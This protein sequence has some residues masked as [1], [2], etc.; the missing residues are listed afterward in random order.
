MKTIGEKLRDLRNAYGL[1][2]REFGEKVGITKGSIN[3]YENNVNSITQGAKWKILQATGIGFE[4]FDSDMTLSEAF[5][6]YNIDISKKLEFKKIEESICA[7]C[8]GVKN[9]IDGK[10]LETFNIKSLFLNHL[11][12]GMGYFDLCFLK[13]KHNELEPYA[14]NGDILVVSSNKNAENGDKIIINYK[15]NILIVQYFHE[16]DKIILKTMSG[17]EIKF[18]NSEFSDCVDIL[19]I[20]KGK[21]YF[22]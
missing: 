11:F 7:I 8:D 10:Y 4:Y 16:F 1:S 14:K 6:K 21:F 20:I 18:Y 15:E 13:V 9:Y 5:K 22:E 19:A 12:D 2:Q 17:E 3:S